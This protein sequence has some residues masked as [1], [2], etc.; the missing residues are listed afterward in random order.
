MQDQNSQVINGELANKPFTVSLLILE[1]NRR[2][3]YHHLDLKHLFCPPKFQ[4]SDG[5]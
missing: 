4:V 5:I 3:S 1:N 2:L